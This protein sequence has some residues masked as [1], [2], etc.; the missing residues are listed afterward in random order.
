M[1]SRLIVLFITGLA[2]LT[3]GCTEDDS[4]TGRG[5]AL[6]YTYD[7]FV[8]FDTTQYLVSFNASDFGIPIQR[9]PVM[10]W[11]V[12]FGEPFFDVNGNGIYEPEID[13]FVIAL[14]NDINQ[15]K[16]RNNQYTSPTDRWSRGVPFDDI[17]GDDTLVTF[18]GDPN[19]DLMPGM[20][21]CDINQNGIRDT[22]LTHNFAISKWMAR[23]SDPESVYTRYYCSPQRYKFEFI[24]DSGIFY[25][26]EFYN[27]A[28][29]SVLYESDSGLYVSLGIPGFYG[30][31]G[32]PL[33]E[34]G[35]IKE[36]SNLEFISPL[37]FTECR[38]YRT[39]EF[40]ASLSIDGKQFTDL[41]LVRYIANSIVYFGENYVFEY[42]FNRRLGL[43]ASGS[44]SEISFNV[45]MPDNIYISRYNYYYEPVIVGDSLLFEMTRYTE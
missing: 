16:D 34:P 2:L 12:S 19:V 38:L 37:N 6:T 41:I 44:G 33:L 36:E 25:S 40:N 5:P 17:N 11:E 14:D 13:S 32:V 28:G 43:F 7:D 22:G 18:P 29:S 1:Q 9:E 4:P 30:S 23:S 39:I 21:Y 26:M 35:I 31:H 8:H 15:D 24:S 20:P 10:S 3:F 42:Y 45:E 27:G